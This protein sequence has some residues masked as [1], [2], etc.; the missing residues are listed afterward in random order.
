MEIDRESRGTAEEIV[1]NGTATTKSIR[2]CVRA[3]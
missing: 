3:N 2:A 1:A